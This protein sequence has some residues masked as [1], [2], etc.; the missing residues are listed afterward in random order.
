MMKKA[1]RKYCVLYNRTQWDAFLPWIMMGYRLSRHTSLGGY[2]PYYL[3]YRRHPV[4]GM[5]IRDIVSEPIDLDSPVTSARILRDRAELFKTAMPMAFDNL[6][7]A[8]HRDT[9]RYAV[10]R[11]GDFKPKMKRFE[12]GDYVY[13]RQ[14]SKDTME[15]AKG[16]IILRVKQLLG[17]GRLLPEGRSDGKTIKDH[18]ENYLRRVGM[19]HTVTPWFPLSRDDFAQ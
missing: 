15:L 6:L 14:Q 18:V 10:V 1:L 5:R 8:Q 4:V 9:E 13:L 3:L 19:Y 12:E 2:S 7:I 17:T 16:R 11:S